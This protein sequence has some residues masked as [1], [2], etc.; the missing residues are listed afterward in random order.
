[1]VSTVRLEGG[2][3]RPARPDPRRLDNEDDHEAF[4][5]FAEWTS[6]LPKPLADSSLTRYRSV[7]RSW[8][9]FAHGRQIDWR[10]PSSEELIAFVAQVGPRYRTRKA[11]SDS[12]DHT[13]LRYAA[14]LRRIFV[15]D[16]ELV[17]QS[18]KLGRQQLAAENLLEDP[19]ALEIESLVLHSAAWAHVMGKLSRLDKEI[20]SP[21]TCRE[22]EAARRSRD[23]AILT[24]MSHDGMT[25]QELQQL[26]TADVGS[27]QVRGQAR[28]TLRI[29]KKS[30]QRASQER[31]VVLGRASTAA[32]T[33]WM[34]TRKLFLKDQMA[35]GFERVFMGMAN[36]A[37]REPKSMSPAAFYVMVRDF[38][39]GALVGSGVRSDQLMHA[40]PNL[41][42]NCHIA[43]CLE[44][45]EPI[46][47]LS[48]RMGLRDTRPLQRIARWVARQQGA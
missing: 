44:K 21:V 18:H 41:L 25:V 5:F 23:R 10:T 14:V 15:I 34:E 6:R 20:G 31:T 7:W 3:D 11:G 26:K 48:L 16:E 35:P 46:D 1:M 13:K 4:K 39:P 36:N 45:G 27:H 12:M 29:T 43:R 22:R 24:L 2:L 38:L 17:E 37:G 28:A 19:N 9:R 30:A 32:L 40:G 42:R 8:V 33:H 47:A